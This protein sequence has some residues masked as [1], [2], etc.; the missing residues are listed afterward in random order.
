MIELPIYQSSDDEMTFINTE[1]VRKRNDKVKHDWIFFH[2]YANTK[3]ALEFLKGEKIWS[4]YFKNKTIGGEKVNYRCNRVKAKESQCKAQLY[5]LYHAAEE[6]VSLYKTTIGHTCNGS[7][8]NG[9]DADV[10]LFINEQMQNGINKP[11]IILSNIKRN[12]LPVP[13]TTQLN[14]YLKQYRVKTLGVSTISMGELK[15]WCQSRSQVPANNDEPFIMSYEFG[16]DSNQYIR[17]FITTTRLLQIA[18]ASSVIHADATYK[19][20]W[21]G[22]PV[23]I[24]GTTDADRKFHPFGLA[25]CNSEKRDDYIFYLKAL[26]MVSPISNQRF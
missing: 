24:I 13:K 18:L 15:E 5:L 14:N 11:K 1:N 19:L 16:D 6:N 26:K 8:G 12:G 7:K 10:K 25:V 20:N 17:F 21:Q 3:E 23:L 9:I 4:Y 2:K 22:Y